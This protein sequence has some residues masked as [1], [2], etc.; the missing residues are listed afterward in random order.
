LLHPE[1]EDLA[2]EP[3]QA[4]DADPDPLSRLIGRQLA[5]RIGDVNHVMILDRHVDP[6]A[7]MPKAVLDQIPGDPEEPPPERAVAAPA[8]EAPK[9]PDEGLLDQV[10]DIRAGRPARRH[11]TPKRR[12]VPLHQMGGG[13]LVPSAPS[14]NQIGI[15]RE[16]GGEGGH[17]TQ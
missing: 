3:R 4:R 2:L 13:L 1:E 12:G 6:A 16:L 17:Q 14:G 9:R 15:V 7:T 8:V 10:L 11:I 5:C